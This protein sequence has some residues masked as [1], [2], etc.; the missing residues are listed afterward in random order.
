M[1][2]TEAQKKATKKYQENNYTFVK[3]RFT[4]EEH[5]KFKKLVSESGKSQ[6]QFML[7][8]IFGN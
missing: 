1:A 4:K 7:D 6:N 3:V 5:D 8:C 2:Q